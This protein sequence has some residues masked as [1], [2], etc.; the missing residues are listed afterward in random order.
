MTYDPFDEEIAPLSE[1]DNWEV[2]T[3][4]LKRSMLWDLLGP[5]KIKNSPG[6]LNIKPASQ[7]VMEAEYKEML[8]RKY[9][10]MPLRSELSLMSYIAAES[11]S[12][13]LLALDERYK[14]MTEEER[15]QFRTHNVAVGAVITDAVL[16][17]LIQEGLLHYG[18]HE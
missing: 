5:M 9:S 10:L 16:G 7:D 3:S 4:M 12:D 1:I 15:V 18:G 6:K 8:S 11:A 17:H 13:A 2:L 14:E